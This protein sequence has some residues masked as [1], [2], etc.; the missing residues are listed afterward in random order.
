[1]THPFHEAPKQITNLHE[2]FQQQDYLQTHVY[3]DGTSPTELLNITDD[4]GDNYKGIAIEE[5]K[6]MHV[7]LVDELH[8]AL[9]EIGWKP[10]ASS[11]HFN[12]EAVKGELVDAFHFFMNLCMIAQVT[13]DDLIQ[14]YIN[15]S[16]K[17]I[18]RQE[19]G[20]DGVSTKCPGCGRALD[21]DAV[22]CLAQVD[23]LDDYPNGATHYYYCSEKR[24]YIFS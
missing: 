21:D 2:M 15:K 10:W 6:N 5:Y 11:Q 8:E 23:F 18:Q 16:A 13:P 19:D 7:A 20:Y 9:N 22:H 17:N 24:D 12:Q 1:M 3:G 4:E 14:G